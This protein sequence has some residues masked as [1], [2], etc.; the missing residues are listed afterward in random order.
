[1]ITF[2]VSLLLLIGGYFIYGRLVEKIFGVDQNKETPAYTKNDGVDY[3]PLSWTKIFFIQFLNIAGLGPIFGAVA[4]AMW[5]PVAF[6]WIVFG[7]ILGGAVHD[8]FS[9]MISVRRGGESI[10]EIIGAYL[11]TTIKQIMRAF[12]VVMMV[13]VGAVFVI[14]PAKILDG[15]TNQWFGITFWATI[16]FVYYILATL[17]PIDKIIGRIY[18]FFGFALMF[19]AIAVLFSIFYYNLPIPELSFQNMHVDSEKYPVFPLLFISIACGAISGFHSTQSP[20]MARCITNEKYGRRVF[21]GAMVAEGIIAL[22]WAAVGM[23][24]WA[25]S[26]N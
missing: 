3:I 16:I 22:I 11:G 13:M 18:P 17:L 24:F 9:G 5:G 4:G 25:G 2:V 20:L 23:S 21:Y 6:L 14:G 10:P 7:N 26:K 19:M 1:M 12:T 8:F 15:L